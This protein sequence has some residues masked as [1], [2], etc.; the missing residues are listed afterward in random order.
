MENKNIVL[1]RGLNRGNIHWADFAEILKKQ[2]PNANIEMIEIPGNG[3]RSN[4]ITPVDPMDCLNELRTKITFVGKKEKFILVG[5]SLGGMLGLLWNEKFPED[6][7]GVVSVNASLDQFSKPWE[8]FSLLATPKLTVALFNKNPIERERPILEVTANN[9]ERIRQFEQIFAE[10]D[11]KHP[12]HPENIVRQ[13]ILASRIYIS[14]AD[15]DK[16]L[17]LVGEKDRLVK[18]KCSK[19][20]AQKFNLKIEVHPTAGHDMPIDDPWWL[21]EKITNFLP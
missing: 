3:L 8:R 9:K 20:I 6:L 11:A 1:L 14:K 12:A 2:M 15:P 16:T 13:L 18:P 19:I 5:V 7:S 10:H 21:A 17:I 4:E